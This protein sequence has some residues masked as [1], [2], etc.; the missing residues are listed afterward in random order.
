[1]PLFGKRKRRQ[2]PIMNTNSRNP[3]WLGRRSVKQ[4]PRPL[5][6]DQDRDEKLATGKLTST[7]ATEN[8][9]I[10]KNTLTVGTWNVQTL[11]TTGKLELLRNKMKR[12]RYDIVGISEVRWTGKDETSNRDFIWSG[13]DKTHVRGVGMLLSERARKA[14]VGYN[15]VNSRVITARFD[16]APYEITVIHAY[17]PSMSSS[18]EDIEA[19]YS[20]LEDALAKVHK[21]DI[22]IITD[23]WNAKIGSDNTD[24]KSV[25]GRYG[26]GDRNERGE[27]FLEFAAIHILYICNTRFEQKPQRKWAW[28]SPDGVHKNMIGLILIQQRWK[29][30]VINYRTFQSADICSDHSLVLCNI[31]LRLKKLYN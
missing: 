20:I 5:L 16:A 1:M 24:W 6:G 8:L 30:S 28:A 18:D 12:F 21:K 7:K 2:K 9:K 22:L 23:D 10:A 19:F 29:S 13:E 31:G 15:P 27:R 26:Y 4:S 17:A 14:L 3:C 11:W 25:M